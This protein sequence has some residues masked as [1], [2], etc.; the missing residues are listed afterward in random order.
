MPLACIPLGV[1][2]LDRGEDVDKGRM[3]YDPPLLPLSCC[4]D[5]RAGLV[6]I[7]QRSGCDAGASLKRNLAGAL[8]QAFLV[9]GLEPLS[10][11]CLQVDRLA[12]VLRARWT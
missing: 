7:E 9:Q 4:T 1:L 3:P 5:T 2:A 12:V 8:L 11:R 6:D 10:Q